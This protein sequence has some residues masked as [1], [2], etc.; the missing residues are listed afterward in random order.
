M[1][2]ISLM[3][4]ASY[5]VLSS[6]CMSFGVK[7]GLTEIKPITQH[8]LKGDNCS[9]VKVVFDPTGELIPISKF[10]AL[11]PVKDIVCYNLEDHAE[12]QAWVKYLITQYNIL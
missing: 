7:P 8:F 10:E 11:C 6:S 1:K 4:I 9:T 12:I 3:L 2:K 5:L